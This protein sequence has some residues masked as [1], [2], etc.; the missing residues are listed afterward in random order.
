MRVSAHKLQRDDEVELKVLPDFGAQ[1]LQIQSLVRINEQWRLA[2][3]MRYYESDG[4]S[5]GKVHQF[6]TAR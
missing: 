4:D 2:T 1:A 3:S 5:D 6:T